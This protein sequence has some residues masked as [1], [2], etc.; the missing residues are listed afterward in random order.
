MSSTNKPHAKDAKGMLL[1]DGQYILHSSKAAAPTAS[2]AGF[3]KGALWHDTLNG[4]LYKNAGSVTSATWVLVATG[5]GTGGAV[6]GGVASITGSGTVVT[7]L[8]TVTAVVATMQ[9]DASL[10]NGIE[11][12]ATIGDQAGTP[13]AGSVILKVWKPTGSG[14]VTPIASAAAVSVNWIAFGV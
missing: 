14:D 13:A 4:N 1:K 10:T 6:R 8:T 7:G 2:A 9:A 11:V 5:S 3:H 12:T